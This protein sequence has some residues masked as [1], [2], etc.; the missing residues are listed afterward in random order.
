MKK[1]FAI[2]LLTM[3]FSITTFSQ[4]EVK[5][6]SPD[7]TVGKLQTMGMLTAELSY[8]VSETDTIYTIVYRNC[9]YTHITDF[10]S[11][12]FDGISDTKN[13]FYKILK[14]FFADENRKN[15]DYKLDLKLGDT[16]VSVS[17]EKMGF[18]TY[19]VRIWTERGYF[20]LVENQVDKLFAMAK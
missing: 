6:A 14:S 17:G 2:L 16:Y 18:G 3:L 5:K 11:F 9:R 13:E 12:R 1:L 7:V 20:Y 4:I 10:K 8:Q 19:C 15:K